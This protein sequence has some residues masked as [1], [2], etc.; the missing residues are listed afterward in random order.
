MQAGEAVAYE[1]VLAKARER[2]NEEA[3]QEL[4][5]VGPPPYATFSDFVVQRKWAA[6][7]AGTP[8][9]SIIFDLLLAPRYSL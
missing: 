6:R 7:F 2:A 8:A 5:A 4:E 1:R 3:I 9:S